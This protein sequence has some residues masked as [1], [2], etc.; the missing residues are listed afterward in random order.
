MYRTLA[1]VHTLRAYLYWG[2]SSSKTPFLKFFN[3]GNPAAFI[4]LKYD[5]L[6]GSR[7]KIARIDYRRRLSS[8]LYLKAMGN[9]AFDV[10][11]R[12]PENTS[13]A[14]WLWGAGLGVQMTTPAGPLELIYSIGS[15]SFEEPGAAQGVTYLVLGARF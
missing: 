3:Q 4:G 8:F 9:A 15:K 6:L 7:M 11:Q 2:E 12:W 10:A 1:K 14:R 13:S 5:Q